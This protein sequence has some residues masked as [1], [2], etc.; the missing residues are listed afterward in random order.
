MDDKL[1]IRKHIRQ[2]RQQL[3]TFERFQL[4]EHL[5]KHALEIID[6]VQPKS[7]AIY[8]PNDGEADLCNLVEYASFKAIN[9]YL[10]VVHPL[11]K[12][13]LWFACYN[14]SEMLYSNR[15]NIY[16]PYFNVNAIKA[17]WEM[18]LVFMPLVA[19]DLNGNRIGMGA[20]FYDYSFQFKPMI[21]KPTLIGCAY[22]FQQINHCPS[23]HWDMPV[24]GILTD[25]KVRMMN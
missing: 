3:E 8:F 4:N 11:I 24:D 5:L 12:R 1:T 2:K 16:E 23:D 7:I 6:K 9:L 25:L 10:P 21:H 14:Q 19:F 13:G 22:E 18:D 20:G 15:Y 17:P